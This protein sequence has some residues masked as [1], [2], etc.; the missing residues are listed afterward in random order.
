MIET[1]DKTQKTGA[2]GYSVSRLEWEKADPPRKML[3]H[4]VEAILVEDEESGGYVASIAQ[5]AGVVSEGDDAASAI[6]NVTEAFLAVIDAYRREGMAI[7]WR[8]PPPKE[9]KEER[10]RI[11]VACPSCR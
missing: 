8:V 2:I 3:G 10:L 7:P 9:P 5:L 4:S 11:V 1:E 6:K